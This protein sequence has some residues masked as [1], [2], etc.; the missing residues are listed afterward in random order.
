MATFAVIETG[1]KQYR[2]TEGAVLSVEKVAGAPGEVIRFDKV[3]LVSRD[4]DV[5]CGTPYLAKRAVEATV[6]GAARGERKVVFRFHSKTRYR[7][8]RTHRQ[9]LT[10]VRITKLE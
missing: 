6:L 5:E 10:T 2:V 4:G 1:G 8:K 3:L 7:K 9:D